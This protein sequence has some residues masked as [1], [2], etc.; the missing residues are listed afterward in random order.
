MFENK[1]GEYYTLDLGVF[2]AVKT[3]RGTNAGKDPIVTES[4]NVAVGRKY[5]GK[6][7]KVF[8]KVEGV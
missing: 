8:V 4:G 5:A 7:V 6:S 1:K 2:E 3:E